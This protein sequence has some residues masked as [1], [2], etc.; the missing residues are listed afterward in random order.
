VSKQLLILSQDGNKLIPN[1][2]I[3]LLELNQ[4]FQKCAWLRKVLSYNLSTKYKPYFYSVQAVLF[5]VN[6]I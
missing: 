4:S 2:P 3:A 6:I 5:F 1:I